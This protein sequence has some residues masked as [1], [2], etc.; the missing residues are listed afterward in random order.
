MAMNYIIAKKYAVAAMDVAKNHNLI[1]QFSD[2]LKKFV[3]A[4]SG[5]IIKELSNPA[6]SRENLR[7]IIIDLGRKLSLEEKVIKFLEIVTESRRITFIHLI[8]KNFSQL[9]KI[10]KNI[11][12]VDVFSA[13]DLDLQTIDAIKAMITGQYINKS[14]E[15]KQFI[16][17]DILGGVQIRIGSTMIDASLKKQLLNLSQQFQLTL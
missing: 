16:K 6:I 15:I 13:C 10:E 17:K 2:D 7:K 9:V 4:V 5:L 11:L 12:E 3:L 1:D 14:I 8:E